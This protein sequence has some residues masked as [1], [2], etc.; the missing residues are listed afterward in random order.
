VITLVYD[1]LLGPLTMFELKKLVCAMKI[2]LFRN[3]MQ[4]SLVGRY[5]CLLKHFASTFTESQHVVVDRSVC[6]PVHSC[7]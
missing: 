1:Q 7:L 4:H 2:T 3:V 6:C 5:Q